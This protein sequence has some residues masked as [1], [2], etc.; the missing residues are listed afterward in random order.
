M[1]VCAVFQRNNNTIVHGFFFTLLKQ[2]NCRLLPKEQQ[3]INIEK[4]K[5]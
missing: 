2:K 1:K 4:K 5:C 3:N